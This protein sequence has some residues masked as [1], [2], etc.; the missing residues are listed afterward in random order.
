[1]SSSLATAGSASSYTKERQPSSPDPPEI[2]A[3]LLHRVAHSQPTG[4]AGPS[5][6]DD[7]PLGALGRPED[8]AAAVLFLVG[9]D[10]EWIKPSA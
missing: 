1:M 4:G 2:S 9:L 3:R 5:G 10:G 8:I 6:R 7:T